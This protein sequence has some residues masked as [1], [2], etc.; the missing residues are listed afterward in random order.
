MGSP[1]PAKEDVRAVLTERLGA[2]EAHPLLR[3][4]HSAVAEPIDLRRGEIYQYVGDEIVINWVEADGV[5]DARAL[6]CF[7]AMRA[8]FAANA[9]ATKE[10][11]SPAYGNLREAAFITVLWR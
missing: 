10:F 7:F 2:L 6:R 4:G 11:F 5:A 9:K 8:A 1:D 3:R